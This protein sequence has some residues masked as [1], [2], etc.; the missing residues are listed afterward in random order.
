MQLTKLGC[1]DS[2]TRMPLHEAQMETVQ[3][4][5]RKATKHW[6]LSVLELLRDRN[7]RRRPAV[8]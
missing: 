4:G 1:A 6:G 5:A 2:P 8:T 7:P 3:V